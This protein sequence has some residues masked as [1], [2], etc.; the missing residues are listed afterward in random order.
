MARNELGRLV[1][2]AKRGNPSA[3]EEL[4]SRLFMMLRPLATILAR[5]EVDDV[6]AE[7]ILRVFE[8]LDR[9]HEEERILFFARAV[10]RNIVREGWKSRRR[11]SVV[12]DLPEPCLPDGSSGHVDTNDL[13][14]FIERHL[15]NGDRDL[16]RRWLLQG[17]S[18]QSLAEELGASANA[19][20]C[21]VYRLRQKLR[22]ILAEHENPGASTHWGRPREA[23]PPIHLL[24]KFL[25]LIFA[26]YSCLEIHSDDGLL[27]MAS[28]VWV[29]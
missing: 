26:T 21:R 20:S 24:S 29:L 3:R 17:Y 25:S 12:D 27:I 18:V 22:L 16:F 11:L 15:K 4:F 5:R 2:E 14:D 13:I 9:I 19:V 28:S 1:R 10:L 6:L 7:A 23:R 8:G